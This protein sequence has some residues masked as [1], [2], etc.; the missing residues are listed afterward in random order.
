MGGRTRAAGIFFLTAL[1]FWAFLGLTAS[2][3]PARGDSDD[4]DEPVTARRIADWKR[5]LE[6]L[7]HDVACDQTAEVRGTTWHARLISILATQHL[8]PGGTR[9]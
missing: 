1:F 9:S 2:P 3:S 6:D 5:T 7:H 4:A 8:R